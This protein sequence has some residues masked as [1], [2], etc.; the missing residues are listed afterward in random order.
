MEQINNKFS[1]EYESDNDK[2]ITSVY[3][4]LN[5]K[6]IILEC[7]CQKKRFCTHT[8]FLIDFFYNYYYHFNDV[9]IPNL[10]IYNGENKL[11]LPCIENSCQNIIN[12][13]L[14]YYSN[15]LYN[16]CSVCSEGINTISK[17]KH[18]DYIMNEF[19]NH[20]YKLKE[21]NMY[22]NNLNLNELK[23]SN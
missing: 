1:I 16:Y 14:L 13:E 2:Q 5:E 11:W 21:E 17:C 4:D 3:F 9:V 6:N 12:V 8:D 20:Y 7:S 18:L 15:S 23:I 19:V 10:K 22:I